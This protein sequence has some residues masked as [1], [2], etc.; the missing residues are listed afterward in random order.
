MLV[1]TD[2]F[3]NGAHVLFIDLDIVIPGFGDTAPSSLQISGTL[4][5]DTDDTVVVS[6]KRLSSSGLVFLVAQNSD[7]LGDFLALLLIDSKPVFKFDLGS[8]TVTI[9][10]PQPIPL[11]VFTTVELRYCM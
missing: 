4:T 2:T 7:G 10:S 9:I 1:D 3:C 5:R 6:V 11:D 8:G